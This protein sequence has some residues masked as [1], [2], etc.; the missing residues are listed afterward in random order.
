M[1]IFIYQIGNVLIRPVESSSAGFSLESNRSFKADVTQ[2]RSGYD[3]TLNSIR[4]PEPMEISLKNSFLCSSCRPNS[5]QMSEI[6]S[7]AGV[8][9]IDIIA[10]I[11][12]PCCPLHGQCSVCNGQGSNLWLH[13]YGI[14]K[15]INRSVDYQTFTEGVQPYDMDLVLN[16]YWTPINK[17]SWS[18]SYGSVPTSL[19][20]QGTEEVLAFP[21]NVMPFSSESNSVYFYKR[22]TSDEFY[23]D[24]DN[25]P[26][27]YGTESSVVSSWTPNSKNIYVAPST[28]VWNFLPSSIYAFTN[29]P[30]S[31]DLEINVI[32]EFAPFQVQEYTSSISI[33]LIDSDLREQGFFGLLETDILYVGNIQQGRKS[34]IFRDGE[35]L[36]Y[37]P[38]WNN[39]P[40]DHA[41][42]LI[43]LNNRVD[44]NMPNGVLA[45]W[46]HTYR[47]L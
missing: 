5:Q 42:Q 18:L 12:N 1:S 10:Y 38:I 22:Q 28:K 19:F 15:S 2:S 44:L 27:F 29:L 33:G 26:T 24:P 11:P 6:M 36:D 40:R 3:I 43:G 13:T 16:T 46:L 47:G 8:P 17:R 45:S 20:D 31:G 32:G 21:E 14:V 9:Y 7:I 39:Y 41:G 37:A 34:V 4:S 35:F 23:Y 25:W 30:D